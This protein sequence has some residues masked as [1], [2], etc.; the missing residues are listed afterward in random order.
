MSSNKLRCLGAALRVQHGLAWQFPRLAWPIQPHP[1]TGQPWT[2]EQ[3]CALLDKRSR[4]HTR[5]E[6]QVRAY[7][8]SKEYQQRKKARV[9]ETGH[10]GG[11]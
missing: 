9:A 8:A 2:L 10:P 4:D 11:L 6:Q 5:K 7:E 1:D 3:V